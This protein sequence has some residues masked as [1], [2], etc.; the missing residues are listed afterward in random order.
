M[1]KRKRLP[2]DFAALLEGGDFAAL[3]AVFDVCDVDA[4]DRPWRRTA[5]GFD[6]CPDELARWLLG[7]GAD[8]SARDAHGATPLQARARSLRGR[9]DGLLALGADVHAGEGGRGTALHAAAGAGHAENARLLLAGGARV[10]ALDAAG[11][12]PLETALLRCS[13]AKLV[14]AA[15]LAGVLLEAGA[16]VTPRARERV[17]AIG[18]A[19]EFHRPGFNPDLVEAASAALER[20]YALF[21]VPPAPRRAMHD[22]IAPIAATAARWQDRHDEL[23]ALLVPSAGPAGTVQGEVVRISGRLAHEIHG[24]GGVN[25]DA[26]FRAMAKAWLAHVGS[27]LAL[28]P[29]ETRDATAVCA[30]LSS[31][32]GDTER[33]RE[34]AVAWVDLNPVPIALPPP[35]Y[36]R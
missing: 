28:P 36:E 11:A 3:E 14:E 19:F 12:T 13:N 26:Q 29:A 9:I 31:R 23:W 1:R 20:L 17:A 25:W 34:L 6:E 24:N 18:S 10:D 35:A 30:G 16:R 7:H 2:D 15:S 8:L 21:G 22:G 32:G 5:L 33:V 4:R 27:G